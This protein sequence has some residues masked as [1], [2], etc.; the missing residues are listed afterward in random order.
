MGDYL[1]RNASSEIR[2]ANKEKMKGYKQPNGMT[3]IMY[4]FKLNWGHEV[5]TLTLYFDEVRYGESLEE[6]MQDK[7]VD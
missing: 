2:K 3:S 1:Y 4:P 6:V 7:A 5:P